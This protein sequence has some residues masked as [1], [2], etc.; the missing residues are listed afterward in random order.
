MFTPGNACSE[1][2][3]K[4]NREIY[5]AC[6]GYVWE[7]VPTWA[8]A[9]PFFVI[10]LREEVLWAQK[11]GE[12]STKVVN[13]TNGTL[14]RKCVLNLVTKGP[15]INWKRK[16]AHMRIDTVTM[17]DDRKI[18]TSGTAGLLHRWG[19]PEEEKWPKGAN[20]MEK[21]KKGQR[22]LERRE[23]WRRLV[24]PQGL[25]GLQTAVAVPI[26]GAHSASNSALQ[27]PIIV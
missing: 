6:I 11:T 26:S 13:W 23:I 10:L 12:E 22:P 4:I 15:I 3:D 20:R 16:L 2:Y 19:A 25:M 8:R 18:W 24:I 17:R 21:G 1:R 9:H 14:I 27:S 7:G 5:G